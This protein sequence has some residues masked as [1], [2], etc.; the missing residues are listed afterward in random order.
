MHGADQ[1]VVDT[2]VKSSEF[3]VVAVNVHN[4]AVKRRCFFQQLGSERIV[5]TGDWN[6]ILYPKVGYY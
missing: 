3:R 1:V 4:Y 2:V 5:L 6:A